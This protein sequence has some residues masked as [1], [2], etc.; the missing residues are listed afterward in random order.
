MPDTCAGADVANGEVYPTEVLEGSSV[1]ARCDNA[2]RLV[3]DWILQCKPSVNGLFL[4][5]ELPKCVP[6]KPGNNA[7]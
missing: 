5:R 3:G 1:T 2:F 6:I 4:D 7:V